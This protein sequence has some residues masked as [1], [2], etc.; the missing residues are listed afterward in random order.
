VRVYQLQA[1]SSLDAVEAAL[2]ALDA[3]SFTGPLDAG[4]GLEEGVRIVKIER[5][6]RNAGSVGALIRVLYK[7]EKRKLWSDLYDFKFTVNAGELEVS[8][9]RV[10]G[11]GR[12]DP[13]FIVNELARVLARQPATVRSRECG[14]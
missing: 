8:V 13:D 4:C 5:L 9:R 3:R 2:K 11:L 12:T 7:V 10:S 1:P 6:E 14:L